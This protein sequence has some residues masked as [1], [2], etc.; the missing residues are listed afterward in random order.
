MGVIPDSFEIKRMSVEQFQ[1][2]VRLLSNRFHVRCWL[3]YNASCSDD[4]IVM[5]ISVLDNIHGQ[6]YVPI[7]VDD[8]VA[9]GFYW[10]QHLG[11][12]LVRRSQLVGR[13]I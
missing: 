4:P 7:M 1:A 10:D 13:N 9:K 2:N 11:L 8:L 3:N 6:G 5:A 12:H